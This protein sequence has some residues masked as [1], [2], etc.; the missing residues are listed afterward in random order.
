[1]MYALCN[2]SGVITFA[3]RP[4]KDLSLLPIAHGPDAKKLRKTIQGF[5]R[6]GYEDGVYLVPGI[7]ENADDQKAGL[8]ALMRFKK[9]IRKSCKKEGITV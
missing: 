8:E 7:P 9:F 5:A 6:R 3:P 4:P 2:A 1:M